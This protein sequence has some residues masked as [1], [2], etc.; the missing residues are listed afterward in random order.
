MKRILCSWFR[1][2]EHGSLISRMRFGEME[3]MGER[4]SRAKGAR[5]CGDIGHLRQDTADQG[6][7]VL[8]ASTYTVAG[9]GC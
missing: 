8:S 5:R 9:V 3:S 7:R 1:I 2:R 6:M 4:G